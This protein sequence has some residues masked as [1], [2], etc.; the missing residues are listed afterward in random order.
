MLGED[1]G[2]AGLYTYAILAML[3]AVFDLTP[4]VMAAA[5]SV[6]RRSAAEKPKGK[7][8]YLFAQDRPLGRNSVA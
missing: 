4:P 2:L 8:D 6:A 7:R 3:G 5:M 1:I